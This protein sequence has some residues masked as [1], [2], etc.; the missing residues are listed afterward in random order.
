MSLGC[1]H[2]SLA[3]PCSPPPSRKSR[4]RCATSAPTWASTSRPARST[5]TRGEDGATVTTRTEGPNEKMTLHSLRQGRPADACRGGAGPPQGGDPDARRE[6]LRDDETRRHHRLPE[7][8]ARQ[9]GRR[10][11]APT[12]PPPSFWSPLTM[13]PRRASRS[14]AACRSTRYRDCG[15]TPSRWN[16]QP[17]D[18]VTVKDKE[19]KLDRLPAQAARRRLRGLGR[20]RRAR[21]ARPGAGRRR[22]RRWSSKGSRTRRAG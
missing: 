11:R 12:G 9:A 13:E 18:T 21:G 8:P 22:R 19:V 15:S 6:G 3:T 2:S 20:R 1:C 14:S 7:G 17:A 5:T 4:W 16:G 10:R